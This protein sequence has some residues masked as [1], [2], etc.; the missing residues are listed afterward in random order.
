MDDALLMGVLNRVQD[1][2]A[3][4]DSRTD[5]QASLVAERGD[6]RTL[7]ALHREVG[8]PVRRDARVKDRRDR[9]VVHPRQGLALH[10]ESLQ[11]LGGVRS[12]GKDLQAS[13][14]SENQEHHIRGSR[15]A[16][17]R[18]RRPIAR[19]GHQPTTPGEGDA[20][21]PPSTESQSHHPL[22]SYGAE[23]HPPLIT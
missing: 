6:L 7:D 3:Q 14:R 22:D 15:P 10:G 16:H 11:Q 1:V 5:I 20:D 12:P 2:D 21:S 4:Q 13:E 8:L 19:F 9:R 18:R 23:A 17:A